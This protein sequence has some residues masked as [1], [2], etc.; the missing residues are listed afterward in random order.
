[1]NQNAGHNVADAATR[2][3]QPNAGQ[4]APA[5]REGQR[6][7]IE[8]TAED[9][10]MAP[11]QPTGERCALGARAVLSM[12]AGWPSIRFLQSTPP[13][14][15]Y[16]LES[17]LRVQSKFGHLQRTLLMGPNRSLSA[18][19]CEHMAGTARPD[20]WIHP[21]VIVLSVANLAV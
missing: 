14:A 12:R 11:L 8:A 3:G 2:R 19:Y 16:H 7:R 10:A 4:V 1:M 6:G 13:S 21:G 5:Q 18:V 15:L 9:Q 17:P 20:G